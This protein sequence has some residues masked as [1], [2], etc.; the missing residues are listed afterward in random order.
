LS[1]SNFN[2]SLLFYFVKTVWGASPGLQWFIPIYPTL[3][4]IDITGK[5]KLDK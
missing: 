4:K 2:P 1:T 3:K 5:K